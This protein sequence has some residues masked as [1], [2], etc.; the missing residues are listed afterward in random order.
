MKKALYLLF[1]VIFIGCDSSIKEPA[2]PNQP[3]PTPTPQPT[4][5][6]TP[7]PPECEE[8]SSNLFSCTWVQAD[9]S[10]L[11]REFYFY[12][13][14][15][16]SNQKPSVLIALHGGGGT[17]AS[18]KNKTRFN[19][20]KDEKNF[21]T[22]YPQGDETETGLSRWQRRQPCVVGKVCDTAFLEHIIDY[23]IFNHDADYEQIHVAGH[24]NGGFMSYFLACNLSNSIASISVVAG[25]M[26]FNTY[27]NCNSIH[28]M[29]VLHIHGL[30]D[31]TIDP[32][33]SNSYRST[34]DVVMFWSE[35]NSCQ[36]QEQIPG[37]DVNGDGNS[38]LL[39]QY[40]DCLNGVKVDFYSHEGGSAHAWPIYRSDFNNGDIDAS[41]VIIDFIQM[42]DINGIKTS[43]MSLEK[44]AN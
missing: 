31:A 25:S 34:E 3:A 24:S 10:N 17:S 12:L 37:S 26:D 14:A 1:T 41:T 23:L 6:P 32:L 18:M 5:E 35:F 22:V 28:P 8:Q 44:N 29:P 33:G 16:D 15:N 30:D 42:F 38:W 43:E 19:E 27:D 11:E 21:I 4:P 13:P 20:L 39:N 36:T 9:M 40:S 7:A 2:V